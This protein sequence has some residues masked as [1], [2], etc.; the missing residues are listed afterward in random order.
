[1]PLRIL[2]QRYAAA[3]SAGLLIIFT[4]GYTYGLYYHEIYDC[5]CFG[6]IDFLDS[7]PVWLYTRNAILLAMSIFIFLY[8][9]NH[10]ATSKDVFLTIVAM[11]SGG[12]VVAY[13]SA[14]SLQNLNGRKINE[15]QQLI[16]I[17][18][19]PL[20]GIIATC[21]DSTYL[22][23]AFSYTCPHCLNSI[24]NLNEY[25]RLRIVDKVVGVARSKNDDNM[26]FNKWFNTQFQIIEIAPD[27]KMIAKELPTVFYIRNDSIVHVFQGEVPCAFLF[28]QIVRKL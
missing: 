16:A 15:K 9:I 8:P 12:C 19:S 20:N 4:L 13:L 24:A 17:S 1:M 18:E 21:P 5:G 10:V 28:D 23:F 6:D 26:E 27:K 14:Q 2:W 11:I 25:E 22:I 7:L 3:I